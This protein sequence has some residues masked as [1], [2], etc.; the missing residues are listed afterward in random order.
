MTC[1]SNVWLCIALQM[2][3]FKKWNNKD[4][5][6]EKLL[7]AMAANFV[8]WRKQINLQLQPQGCMKKRKGKELWRGDTYPV[9][10]H[11]MINNYISL[12]TS[13]RS[14]SQPC[15]Q[16]FHS[17]L[18]QLKCVHSLPTAM[19]QKHSS[20]SSSFYVQ[21]TKAATTHV[22][23]KYTFKSTKCKYLVK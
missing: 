21:E 4:K 7:P 14:D 23:L 12:F 5:R 17:S 13:A 20:H 2:R 15:L 22:T 8:V 18:S 19:T 6:M 16:N 3:K 1:S 10:S 9:S 11:S